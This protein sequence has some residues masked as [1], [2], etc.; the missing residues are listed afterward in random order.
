[1]RELERLL[2][3]HAAMLY[4][5]LLRL[6]EGDRHLADDLAQETFLRALTLRA[7]YRGEGPFG[8]WLCGIARNLWRQELQRRRR[9]PT[10]PLGETLAAPDDP[11]AAAE[12]AEQRVR[13]YRAL[14]RLPEPYREVALLRLT[15]GLAFREIGEIMGKSE[16][17]ARVTFFRAR[18]RLQK[19][20]LQ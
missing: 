4:G 10:E 3:E 16:N 8:A 9:H 5:Y 13:I 20:D 12:A 14:H 18:E 19:E 15:G 6:T 11:A 1:M 2:E 17:W 7:R